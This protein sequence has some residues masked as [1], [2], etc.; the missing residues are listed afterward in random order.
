MGFVAISVS[1]TKF[2]EWVQTGMPVGNYT[3]LLTMP[4][5]SSISV[6]ESGFAYLELGGGSAVAFLAT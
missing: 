1:N 5:S 4:G 2:G 6:T 3:N